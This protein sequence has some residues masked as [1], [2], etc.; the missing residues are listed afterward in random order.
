MKWQKGW[1]C[2][3]SELSINSNWCWSYSDDPLGPLSEASNNFLQNSSPLRKSMLSRRCG[4]ALGWLIC[5]QAICLNPSVSHTMPYTSSIWSS[6]RSPKMPANHHSVLQSL[7]SPREAEL[8]AIGHP[9]HLRWRKAPTRTPLY[10]HPPCRPQS[11]SHQWLFPT[12]D[13]RQRD[14]GQYPQHSH[15]GRYATHGRWLQEHPYRTHPRTTE[16]RGGQRAHAASSGLFGPSSNMV[17]I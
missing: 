14:W 12:H 10:R 3:R 9:S 6:P 7:S 11:P 5:W 13:R 16:G 17:P 2:F 15:H 8:L 1:E 4:V